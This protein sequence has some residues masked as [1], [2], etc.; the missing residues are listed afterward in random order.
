MK[1]FPGKACQT[2]SETD[3]SNLR[4]RGGSDGELAERRPLLEKHQ[5]GSE[6][7]HRLQDGDQEDRCIEQDIGPRNREDD[8]GLQQET[9]HH[10]S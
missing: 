7:A 8:Q 2:S 1:P 9:R 6:R 4:P 5:S 10:V 3:L